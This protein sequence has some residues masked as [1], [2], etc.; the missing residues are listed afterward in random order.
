MLGTWDE[1]PECM[2]TGEVRQYYEILDKRRGQLA[3]KRVFDLVVAGFLFVILS[4]VMLVISV[5]I[6]TD[7]QGGILYRQERVTQNGRVFGIHKFRTMVKDADRIG[8]IFAVC[9]LR[10][11]G[12]EI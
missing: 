5:A 1:L 2:K 3:V 11:P 8:T 6:L 9:S 10:F 4:P 7:S 12:G